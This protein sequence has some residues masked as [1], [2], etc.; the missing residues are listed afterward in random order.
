MPTKLRNLINGA[1]IEKT[2]AGGE[3]LESADLITKKDQ[4]LYKDGSG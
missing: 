4:F 3:K 1:V 2:F